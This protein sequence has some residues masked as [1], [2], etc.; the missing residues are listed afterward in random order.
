MH[1][2]Y[3]VLNESA[4]IRLKEGKN[5]HPQ[6]SLINKLQEQTSEGA[7]TCTWHL[8]AIANFLWHSPRELL[9]F[10]RCVVCLCINSTRKSHF[11]SRYPNS[12]PFMQWEDYF[13]YPATLFYMSWVPPTFTN[14][15]STEKV[16]FILYQVFFFHFG[17]FLKMFIQTVIFLFFL[18]WN[19]THFSGLFWIKGII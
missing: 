14:T 11:T 13:W 17:T 7:V 9:M 6:S 10:A 15:S 1:L 19:W 12:W 3:E 5:N 18:S 4:R 2:S 8:K 16:S